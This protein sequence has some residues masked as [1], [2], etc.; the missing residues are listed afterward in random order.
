MNGYYCWSKKL[1]AVISSVIIV[2]C[3]YEPISDGSTLAA[4]TLQEKRE[5][6]ILE[7]FDEPDESIVKYRN[8][9]LEQGGETGIDVVEKLAAS[10]QLLRRD[11]KNRSMYISFIE[12]RINDP[13][14]EIQSI[15]VSALAEDR[16]KGT[17]SILFSKLDSSSEIVVI[18]AFGAIKHRLDRASA[19]GGSN[20]E[21]AMTSSMVR[22]YCNDTSQRWSW[23]HRRFCESVDLSEQE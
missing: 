6:V 9:I 23:G 19:E 14:P 1:L 8:K 16:E 17:I 20:E 5:K 10:G 3:S 15:A 13:N 7:F 2:A 18:E 22:I 11:A 4:M 12:S 21:N